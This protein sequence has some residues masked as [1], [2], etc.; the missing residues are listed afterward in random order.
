MKHYKRK[1]KYSKEHK[2]DLKV[3]VCVCVWERD[4][5]KRQNKVGRGGEIKKK[6][7]IE[8]DRIKYNMQ[9]KEVKIPKEELESVQGLKR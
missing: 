5:R 1:L 8:S 3:C 7:R 4:W 2:D 9:T 6:W